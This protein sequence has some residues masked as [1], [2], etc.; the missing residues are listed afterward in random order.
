MATLDKVQMTL[1]N[2]KTFEGS[3]NIEVVESQQPFWLFDGAQRL[4]T[5][6]EAVGFVD[7]DTSQAYIGSGTRVRSWTVS[8]IQWEGSTDSWGDSTSDDD[9]TQ[10]LCEFGQELANSSIDST[11]P[12]T[13]EY[14]EYTSSGEQS[15]LTVVPG[16][17]TLPVSFGPGESATT[18]Q[19]QI[20][21]LDST[22]LNEEKHS[23]P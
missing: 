20:Q 3:D 15:E 7:N 17:V 10:K 5:L 19:P 11:N 9:V 14:G 1:P 21:W 8:F 6:G 16:E 2:G 12:A 22:A 4:R 23:P 13:L 18:F